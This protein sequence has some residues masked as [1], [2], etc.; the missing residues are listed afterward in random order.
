M[1]APEL[2]ERSGSKP[3]DAIT[4][5]VFAHLV[6][7]A[8]LALDPEEGKY[9]REELNHQLK[10]IRELESIELDDGVPITSHGVPYDGAILPPIRE[11]IREE[12]SK[13]DA[14]VAGAP[15]SEARYIVV[16]DIPHEELE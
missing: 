4:P 10:A 11:D 14:I 16:P 2:A 5:E 9:L 7:L 3:P 6:E 8:A 13:A 1:E 15:E 12:S